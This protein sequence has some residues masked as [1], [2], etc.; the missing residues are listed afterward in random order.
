[1]RF[2]RS[3]VLAIIFLCTASIHAESEY[4]IQPES[5]VL[6]SG[7]LYMK[8]E[9]T[10]IPLSRIQYVEGGVIAVPEAGMMLVHCSRCN[11]WY[12]AQ[13]GHHCDG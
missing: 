5:L 12:I 13:F 10:L 8:L 2:V 6:I 1:M 4:C 9:Q 11:E 7:K 3:V